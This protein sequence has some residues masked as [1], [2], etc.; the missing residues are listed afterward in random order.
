MRYLSLVCAVVMFVGVSACGGSSGNKLVE[1]NGKKIT[2]G[3][4]D[5]L[6]D[7]NPRVKMEA[8]RPEG[9]KK[10]LDNLVEQEILFQE[11]IK[12]GVDRNDKVKKQIDLYRQIIIAQA[13]VDKSM[14][15]VAKKY[16]DEHQDEFKKLK[17]SH[18]MIRYATPEEI[19]KADAV[20]KDPKAINKKTDDIRSEAEALKYAT[21]IK[22]KL[23]GG[24][25]FASLVKELSD[26]AATKGRGGDLGAISKD[27]KRLASR[28]IEAI[29]EKAFEMKVGEFSGPIKTSKGYHIVTVTRGVELEPFDEAKQGILGRLGTEERKNYI[30]KLKKDSSIK[31]FDDKGEKVAPSP[32][33]KPQGDVAV[34]QAGAVQDKPAVAPAEAPAPA[35]AAPKA[36]APADV[37]K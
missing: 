15:D 9:K 36:P 17:L 13:L 23:D 24:A 33:V 25:D 5:F 32:E 30:E 27:D 26:D 14:N 20:K 22:A 31:Y 34:P 10:I 18:L 21:D 11:A 1:V 7:I 4:V 37:K 2:Q 3:D 16:W 29:G 6:S 35:P 19:K 28:G 12:Q 8:S